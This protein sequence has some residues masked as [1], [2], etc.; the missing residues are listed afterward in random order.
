MKR[1]CEDGRHPMSSSDFRSAEGIV[2]VNEIY[3][4]FSR[5]P[6][7]VPRNELAEFWGFQTYLPFSKS[8]S[9]SIG[10]STR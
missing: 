1:I 4:P 6:V 2:G 9:V 10:L 5:K 3:G 8:V 7:G